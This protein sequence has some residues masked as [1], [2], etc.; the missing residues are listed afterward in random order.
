LLAFLVTL[1]P[2]ISSKSVHA[3]E[4]TASQEC[5]TYEKQCRTTFRDGH[6]NLETVAG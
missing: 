5:V 6:L 4:I 1:L 2:K 3:G